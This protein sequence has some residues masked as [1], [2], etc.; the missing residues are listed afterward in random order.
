MV[1]EST[2]LLVLDLTGTFVFALNGALTAIEAA[3]VDVVGVVTLGVITAIGGGTIRDLLI[4]AVPPAAFQDWRYLAVAMGGGLV[5]FGSGQRLGKVTGIITIL[6][7][8]GLSMF[9][10]TG[11]TKALS[12]GLGAMPAVILGAVTAVGGGTIRD[13]LV[14]RVPSVLHSEGTLYAI[15]A[16]VAAGIAVAASS[17]HV[18]G[19]PA[20]LGAVAACFGIRMLAVRYHVTAPVPRRGQPAGPA[21]SQSA[22]TAP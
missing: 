10:V 4:G 3:R 11:A 17:A 7:A 19:L 20:A 13:V 6:D 8:A 16:L 1:H 9:A 21:D 12:F 2:L 18:Y 22:G 15:P 14:R 5:A